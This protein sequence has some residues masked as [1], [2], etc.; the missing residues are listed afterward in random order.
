MNRGYRAVRQMERM[1][2]G[3]A[4]QHHLR[5]TDSQAY[6]DHMASLQ[7]PVVDEGNSKLVATITYDHEQRTVSVDKVDEFTST[8]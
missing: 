6:E 1:F 4:Q 3:V 5:A 7:P 2:P 8:T